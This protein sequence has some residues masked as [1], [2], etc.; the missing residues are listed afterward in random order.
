MPGIGKPTF[1]MREALRAQEM[2]ERLEVRRVVS[3]YGFGEAERVFG[4]WLV[5]EELSLSG[6]I[7]LLLRTPER[8]AVVDFKLTA[9][10]PGENHRL[11]LAGYAT[12][13]EHQLGLPVPTLFLYRIPDDRVFALPFDE[14]LR[15][16]TRR[17]LEGLQAM[18]DNEQQPDPTSVRGRCVECEY[19]NFCGDIW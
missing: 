16:K 9:G 7:D 2:I 11:Q 8:A 12:L 4:L 10:D 17:A 18:R 5:D 3:R 6:K 19:A 15:W 14:A 13:V 1:K